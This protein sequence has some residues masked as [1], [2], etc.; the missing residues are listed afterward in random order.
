VPKV[1]RPNPARNINRT[2]ILYLVGS[3]PLL[4]K[5]LSAAKDFV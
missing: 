5:K 2:T 1:K 4:S 3:E